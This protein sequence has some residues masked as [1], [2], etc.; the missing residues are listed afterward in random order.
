MSPAVSI[1]QAEIAERGMIV[2]TAAEGP[3]IL[4][5]A[6]LDGK[7]VDARDPKP[8]QALL[9]EFPVLVAVAAVP[10]VAVVVPFVGEAHGNTVLTEGPELL[11]QP[12]VELATPLSLQEGLDLLAPVEKFRA[13]A[14]AAVDRVG[15][16]DARRV[17][18]V[19]G[20]FGHAHF[21]GGG[22]C[23]KGRKRW[24]AHGTPR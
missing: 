6:R 10:I 22:L 19:P 24:T 11:D 14:P 4:A 15:E 9:V 16:H 12:I 21:L 18:R 13:V 3:M 2:G 7:V 17:A 20:I 5:L 1:S 8:H 23:G